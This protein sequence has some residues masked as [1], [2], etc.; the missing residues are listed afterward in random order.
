[1]SLTYPAAAPS[2]GAPARP[3]APYPM[4][5]ADI[6]GTH[7]RLARRCGPGEPFRDHRHYATADFAGIADVVAAWIEELGSG[8]DI[9]PDQPALP[10]ARA[11]LAVAA[12]VGHGP[13]RL[14]NTDF[15]VDAAELARRFAP[16]RV[17]LM[18]DFEAQAWSLP[19]LG[20]GDFR[21]LGSLAPAGDRTMAVLGPGTGLGCAGLV[22][23]P[24]GRWMPLPGE[25]G[26]MTLAA[27]TP[28]EA[29]VIAIARQAFPHVSAER[30]VS[31]SGL[32]LLY[33]SL[34]TARGEP[35]DPA[36]DTGEEIGKAID[37]SPL[38]AAAIDLFGGLL[39]GFAGNVALVLGAQGGV[40]IA[41][42]VAPA[43]FDALQASPFRERFEGKG[44]FSRY[45]AGIGTA[46]VTRRD[47]ALDGLAF[48][49]E[50]GG[51]DEDN[52][53]G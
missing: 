12:P 32:P 3:C 19:T 18:N 21:V 50:S 8:S 27:Q 10:F 13:I 41:G 28:L 4:L 44:R 53:A 49:L 52:G 48:A 37:S 43:L 26:H 47:P 24:A 1:M 34:A 46:V 20:A 14:T 15:V 42:G 35:A 5:L 51:L 38:A 22:R 31:G 6:G 9:G 30:L 25:G 2:A 16:C 45:L 7:V 17:H 33:R 36:L 23:T 39:G 11:V 40:W 29:E